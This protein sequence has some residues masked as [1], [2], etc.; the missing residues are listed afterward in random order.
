MRVVR[1]REFVARHSV[2]LVAVPLV[3]RS[4]LYAYV[5]DWWSDLECLRDMHIPSPPLLAYLADNIVFESE[6]TE[7]EWQ[8][9]T[10]FISIMVLAS[11]LAGP[12]NGPRTP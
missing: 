2:V 10:C 8:I 3:G 9:A 1:P 6:L 5:P 12:R 7:A 4:S 11:F